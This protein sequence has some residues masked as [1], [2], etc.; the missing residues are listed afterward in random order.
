MVA[1]ERQR[2]MQQENH[3]DHAGRFP[4]VVVTSDPYNAETRLDTQ[5]GVLTPNPAFYVRDHFSMP[6][7]D[8]AAWRLT[9]DGEVARPLALTYDALRA[10]PSRSLLV[11]L[12][13]AGN[14][15]RALDPPAEGEP[16]GYGVASTA[17]WTGVPLRAVLEAASLRQN[18]REVLFTGA[19][20][21][22]VPEAGGATMAF[23]RSLPVERAL[24][25]DTLLAY[26]MNGEELPAAHGFPLRVLVPGWYG[27]A[28]VKWLVRITALA[29]PF[30]GFYQRDRYVVV[31]PERGDTTA[32][33]LTTIPPRSLL[34]APT[35]GARLP[36]GEQRL[37]GLA[38]SGGAP[39][40]RVEVSMDD[41]RTWR[42]AE[43]TSEPAR[44][45]WRTWDYRWEATSPGPA[46]LR[47]RAF[48]AAG[49]TQPASAEWN[50]L[51]YANNAI[52]VVR[53][54]VA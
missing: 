15:R 52:Q 34:G 11:T 54:T 48:D 40:E 22:P 18:A 24:H 27:V 47:S 9:L 8:P 10:L 49:H 30:A 19:D 23:A 29:S 46:T 3:E 2:A 13:C 5:L 16:F 21:G 36:R 28:A 7:I 44:Y 42:A 4:L 1:M 50:R 37:R 43:W 33:P 17:E 38:W 20:S 51:G 41:G 25:P 26:A 39:V 14:G 53:V 6:R 31:H 32:T 12:E 35:D 45:A